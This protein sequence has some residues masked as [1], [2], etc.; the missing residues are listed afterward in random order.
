MEVKAL[1]VF[2][3]KK[4]VTV[5]AARKK[6]MAYLANSPKPMPA[7]SCT[8]RAHDGDRR[9]CS[10]PPSASAQQ[11]NKGTSV[12]TIADD[13]HKAGMNRYMAA[14][15]NPVLSSNANRAVLKITKAVSACK[16]GDESLTAHSASPNT[17]VVVQMTQAIKGGLVKYPQSK[18]LDHAQY[19][20]SSPCR[21]NGEINKTP[22]R[23]MSN[24]RMRITAL[25]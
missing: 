25:R 2:G 15:Q 10:Q 14:A 18:A 1:R 3:S 20:A 16:I 24:P 23:R 13:S 11:S 22:M 21:P 8:P 7:P 4:Y 6:N 19:C 17:E 9:I 5:S 12:L